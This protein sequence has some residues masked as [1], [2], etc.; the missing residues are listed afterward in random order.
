MGEAGE[1]ADAKGAVLLH[2]HAP[3][4]IQ[5]VNGDQLL[6]GPFALPHLHQHVGSAG[7][8]LG[9]RMG[10]AEGHGVGHTGSLIQ[11]FH[12]IHRWFPPLFLDKPRLFELAIEDVRRDGTGVKG[13]A[14]G[15]QNGI[16]DGRGRRTGGGL[17]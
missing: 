4:L 1:G 5:A 12:I 16:A 3:E 8:D 10:Q 14:G 7:D 11:C 15:V 9:L 13:D 6:A 2:L 17:A